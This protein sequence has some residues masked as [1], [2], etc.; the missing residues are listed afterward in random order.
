M[1]NFILCVVPKTAFVAKAGVIT[2]D[3]VYYIQY[4]KEFVIAVQL[5]CKQVYCYVFIKNKN[6]LLK[7][8][9]MCLVRAQTATDNGLLQ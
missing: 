5:L 6:S 4:F 1:Y 2:P 9:K 8:N 3:H 7:Y